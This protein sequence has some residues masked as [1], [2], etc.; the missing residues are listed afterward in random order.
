MNKD[1]KRRCETIIVSSFLDVGSG[2]WRDI[3]TRNWSEVQQMVKKRRRIIY[4][5]KKILKS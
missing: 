1:K 3:F 4:P 5:A 2:Y